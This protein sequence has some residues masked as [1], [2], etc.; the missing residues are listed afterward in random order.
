MD[1]RDDAVEDVR[2]I[3]VGFDGTSCSEL[4]LGWAAEAAA[5]D[6]RPLTLVHAVDLNAVAMFPGYD[7]SID[8]QAREDLADDLLSLGTTQAREVMGPKADIVALRLMGSAAGVLVDASAHADLVVT[9]SRG[10]GRL[11]SGLLGST[12][13]SVTAHAACPAVVVRGPGD[14][15][16]VHPGPGKPV[17]VGI[18][19]SKQA[20]HALETAAQVAAAADA[21]LTIVRVVS[22]A[23]EAGALGGELGHGIGH[24]LGAELGREPLLADLTV[25]S[26]REHAEASVAEARA[27]VEAAHPGLQVDGDVPL[28]DPGS[29][30]GARSD[31]AGLVVL[32]SHGH[33]GF[34]GML[35]GS[36]SHRVIHDA[37]C[38]VMVVR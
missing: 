34:R 1:A 23:A 20:M 31:G 14:G 33:G 7:P 22:P 9:G 25:A 10:H 12:S 29:V 11:F 2:G 18:D 32:G 6:G 35:L 5:R 38:P 28:G 24:G 15:T 36:V 13:Y 17:V 37:V 3:V 27:R 19:D 26:V 21:T 16:V 4:A 8:A 30:L